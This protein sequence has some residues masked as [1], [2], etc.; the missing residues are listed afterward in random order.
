MASS[1]RDDGQDDGPHIIRRDLAFL[2]MEQGPQPQ[3]DADEQHSND[4]QL[5]KMIVVHTL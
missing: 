4:S 5:R 2:T 1:E 3:S